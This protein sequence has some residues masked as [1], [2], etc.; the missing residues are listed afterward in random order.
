MASTSIMRGL[1]G[2]EQRPPTL[3]TA[4]TGHA[5]AG[6]RSTHAHGLNYTPKA[7]IP[8]PN[9]AAADGA[10]TGGCGVAVVSFDATNV[11]VRCEKT[12]QTFSLLILP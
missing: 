6:T 5:T 12:A 2:A 9:E 10:L 3:I 11:V 7:V 1:N 8:I 4:L